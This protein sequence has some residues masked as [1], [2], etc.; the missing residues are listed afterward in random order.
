MAWEPDK[1]NTQHLIGGRK[2]FGC[3][4][5]FRPLSDSEEQEFR[6]YARNCDPDSLDKWNIYHPVCREEWE[7]RGIKPCQ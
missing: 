7:K 5:Y 3:S 2:E 4:F 1:T 6:W